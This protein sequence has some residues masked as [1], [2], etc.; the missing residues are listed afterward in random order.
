[1]DFAVDTKV[2]TDVRTDG[3]G[4][5]AR[6][7]VRRSVAGSLERL[8]RTEEAGVDVLHIHRADPATPLEEQV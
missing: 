2:Y 6:D 4:D 8:R 7:A 3:S 1:M 5:L